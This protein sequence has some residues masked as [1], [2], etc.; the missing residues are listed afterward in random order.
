MGLFMGT[1][2]LDTVIRLLYSSTAVLVA[3]YYSLGFKTQPRMTVRAKRTLIF[4]V[5]F[6]A[7]SVALC[8]SLIADSRFAVMAAVLLG[9]IAPVCLVLSLALINPYFEKK[10]RRFIE[11]ASRKLHESN[12]IKIGIT[13]SYGKTSCKNILNAMLERKYSVICT[14]KNYNTPMG[15]ALTVEKMTGREE[16]FIAEM[17]ARRRGDIAQLAEMV[18]PDYSITTGVCAQHLATFKSLHNIYLEKSELSKITKKTSVFNCNDKYALKMYKEHKGR[19]IKVCCN[20]TGDVYATEIRCGA[21]GSEFKLCYGNESLEL[22]TDI[23]GRHN[24]INIALC[25]ALALELGVEAAVIKDV[26]G[27][28]KPT[29]HRLE[30][31]Y[32]NGIHIL[33]DSYNSNLSGVRCALEVLENLG[34]RKIVVAQGIVEC[35]KEAA[36]INITVGRELAAHADVILLCGRNAK[37]LE[38]GIKQTGFTGEIYRYSCIDKAQA[39]FNRILRHGDALLLQNDLPDVY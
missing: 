26:V 25:A 4:T 34:D 5:G 3:F 21:H 16:I 20:K 6:A 24:I 23:L 32:S 35:G 1:T 15:I 13:G 9:M 2:I 29:P 27:E 12:A 37:Y 39:D 14:D 11:S 17:G 33:D 22:R 10:N 7:L 31:I 19:K 8:I 38:E 36:K 18:K 28:L 30:Y